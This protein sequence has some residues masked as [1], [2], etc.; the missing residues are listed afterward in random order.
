MKRGVIGSAALIQ[1]IPNGFG[2]KRII[3]AEELRFY[4]LYWDHVAIPKSNIIP[5]AIPDED[6]LISCGAI[7]RPKAEFRGAI[8]RGFL[9]DAF[10]GFQTQLAA[11]Y[12]K[13]QNTAWAMHQFGEE[14]ALPTSF[15]QETTALRVALAA[16]LPVP[17]TDVPLAEVLEFKERKQAKLEAIH[18]YIDNL[19]LET[20]KSPDILL[21]SKK[22]LSQFRAEVEAL[23]QDK[24]NTSRWK[25]LDLSIEFKFEPIKFLAALGLDASLTNPV[26]LLTVASFL[27]VK[28]TKT[29]SEMG[30]NRLSY[31]SAAA[32][33]G[34]LP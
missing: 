28:L 27:E 1:K 22:T 32:E 6:E 19:Y 30:A 8:D 10:L 7:S 17:S 23:S 5:T 14:I 25:R 20:L 2:I 13:D 9:A 29:R 16:V 34:I 3:S 24:L 26:P 18:E 33:V 31:L 15:S 11:E 21:Q 4:I 12:A